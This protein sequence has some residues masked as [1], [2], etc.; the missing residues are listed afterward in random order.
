MALQVAALFQGGTSSTI[1]RVSLFTLITFITLLLVNVT[2][3]LGVGLIGIMTS[4]GIVSANAV[5]ITAGYMQIASLREQ[6]KA[7]KKSLADANK[8]KNLMR[9]QAELAKAREAGARCTMESVTKLFARRSVAT[10]VA[11]M[12]QRQEV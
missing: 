6:L 12:L 5:A 10:P 11:C 9:E 4:F 2:R 1:F 8:E 7:S 3:T